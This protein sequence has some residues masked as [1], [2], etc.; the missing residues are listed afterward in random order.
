MAASPATT[1]QGHEGAAK[2]QDRVDSTE[3][4]AAARRMVVSVR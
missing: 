2:T 3:A 4:I 1:G